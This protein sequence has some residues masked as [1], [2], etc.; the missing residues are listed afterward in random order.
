MRRNGGAVFLLNTGAELPQSVQRNLF[1]GRCGEPPGIIE[2]K[3]FRRCSS[4]GRSHIDLLGGEDDFKFLDLK[5]SGRTVIDREK[6]EKSGVWR[7]RICVRIFPPR[8]RSDQL[9][10]FQ[11][12][13]DP[14][15]RRVE[16]EEVQP[17]I[18]P[19]LFPPHAIG[20]P[21]FK[22]YQQHRFFPAGFQV[23]NR[24]PVVARRPGTLH[25]KSGLAVL[26]RGGDTLNF[27]F[28]QGRFVQQICTVPAVGTASAQNL[29]GGGAEKQAKRQKSDDCFHIG[30][31][32][33][34]TRSIS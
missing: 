19:P 34:T 1:P 11:V 18:L 33:F 7:N 8:I 17:C 21:H 16:K 32:H 9:V 23:R 4:V 24:N 13:R 29:P 27:S 25:G 28:E 12:W 15:P 5:L 22:A 10:G 30:D 14:F 6:I 26:H 2:R 31:S 20:G 3:H